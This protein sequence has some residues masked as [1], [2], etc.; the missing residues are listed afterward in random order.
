LGI[1]WTYKLPLLAPVFERIPPVLKGVF[2]GAENGFSPNQ[3]AG[4]L[5]FVLPLLLAF[6]LYWPQPHQW[7]RWLWW[8]TCFAAALIGCVLLLTQSRA[9]W[10][11]MI[12]AVISLLLLPWRWGRW[13]LLVTVLIVLGALISGVSLPSGPTEALIVDGEGAIHTL[14]S[15]QEI[16]SSALAGIHDFAFTGM[17]LGTFRSVVHLLYPIPSSPAQYDVAHAHNFFL[18]SALDLGVPGLVALCSIYLT[19]AAQLVCLWGWSTQPESNAARHV[20]GWGVWSVGFAACLIGQTIYSMLD[21]VAL[22]SK[23]SFL[24]WVLFALI[25]AAANLASRLAAESTSA[26]TTTA[27]LDLGPISLPAGQ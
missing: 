8:L 14:L 21:A 5:L 15:R 4:A 10:L 18:Q 3:V 26:H 13:A 20:R 19:A 23:P 24:F 27:R 16:W 9:G 2:Q 12:C 1:Q 22:G 25:F 17:G 7:R 11:G 6:I